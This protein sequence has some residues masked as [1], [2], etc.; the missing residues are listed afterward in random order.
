[1]LDE[2]VGFFEAAFVQEQLNALARAQFPLTVLALATFAA[3]ALFGQPIAPLQ[4][5]QQVLFHSRGL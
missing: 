4:L 5:I 1:M 3:S 2:A